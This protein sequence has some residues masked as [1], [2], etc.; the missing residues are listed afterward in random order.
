M[1]DASG[2][3]GDTASSP[4]PP[5]APDPPYRRVTRSRDDRVLG[6]VAAGIARS[7]GVDPVIVRLAFVFVTLLAGVGI[8]LYLAGWLLIP[9][10]PDPGP[11]AP[12]AQPNVRQLAGFAVLGLGLL[13]VA[14]SFD[15]WIEER[16]L[17]ALG[18][19]AIGGAVLWVRG[20][21]TRD[22][23]SAE[24]P[25]S[26][27]AAFGSWPAS[28]PS[29]P[30]AASAPSWTPASPA[31]PARPRRAPASLL[32]LFALCALAVWAGV[33][34]GLHA[35]GVVEVGASFVLAG[36]LIVVGAALVVGARWGRARWLVVP[37]VA[38]ALIATA[39]S[40]LDLPLA[41]GIGERNYRPT[42]FAVLEDDYELGLGSLH[43]D[44]R[45]LDFA[46][47]RETVRVTVGVGE[48]NVWVPDGVR[49]VVDAH[50]RFGELQI[51]GGEQGGAD[52]ED[53]VVREGTEGTGELRL[54]LEGGVGS[55]KVFDDADDGGVR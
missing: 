51:L 10:G 19:I 54:E 44:L 34:A 4:P 27:P 40:A 7:A 32:G 6:G 22:A 31:A 39:W 5:P 16:A 20:R 3:T 15:F 45:E 14:G 9:E 26:G 8:L 47:R 28:P 17:W 25:D 29:A 42:S 38:L 43:L 13:V 50:V 2:A 55:V 11:T 1:T 46:G 23:A 21:D 53:R 48:T 30:S 36:A 24:P 33:A 49:T 35:L 12:R 52:V 18:L 37:G 41:G